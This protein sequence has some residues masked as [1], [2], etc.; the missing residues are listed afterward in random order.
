MQKITALL[1]CFCFLIILAASPVL[2]TS[3]KR[4]ESAVTAPFHGPVMAKDGECS[5]AMDVRLPDIYQGIK[6]FAIL[7]EYQ[8]YEHKLETLSE[9]IQPAY[10]QKSVEKALKAKFQRCINFEKDGVFIYPEHVRDSR[11]EDPETYVV[12][13]YV[14]RMP[15]GMQDGV[16][17]YFKK[18]EYRHNHMTFGNMINGRMESTFSLL[19]EKN[20][21]SDELKGIVSFFMSKIGYK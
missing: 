3:D 5:T 13:I 10:I 1:L 11:L 18:S 16:S 9:Y 2:A 8:T 17:W 12:Y 21:S 20:L 15:E 4:N 19:K 7:I 14:R 6:R